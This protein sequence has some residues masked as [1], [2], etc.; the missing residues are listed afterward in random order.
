MNYFKIAM[1][2]SFSFSAFNTTLNAS[3][4]SFEN[5]TLFDFEGL[6]PTF[7][8]FLKLKQ[9][10]NQHFDLR[11][12]QEGGYGGGQEG[13]HGGGED[14][15]KAYCDKIYFED[16]VLSELQNPNLEKLNTIVKNEN[17]K[18]QGELLSILYEYIQS[19]QF[20]KSSPLFSQV[21]FLKENKDLPM[22]D[23][24]YHTIYLLGLLNVIA[25]Q[26]TDLLNSMYSIS[27]GREESPPKEESFDERVLSLLEFIGNKVVNPVPYNLYFS[28]CL[29]RVCGLDV[30]R[31]EIEKYLWEEKNEKLSLEIRKSF[32]QPLSYIQKLVF[33]QFPSI[34]QDL[35]N[36]EEKIL[37]VETLFQSIEG[38]MRAAKK[39][40]DPETLWEKFD[41]I[42]A[43]LSSYD[44]EGVQKI[45]IARKIELIE[46][47]RIESL[48]QKASISFFKESDDEKAEKFYNLIFEKIQEKEFNTNDKVTASS[49]YVSLFFY[50]K[51]EMEKAYKWADYI[52]KK[53]DLKRK[54]L[55]LG[56]LLP[57]TSLYNLYTWMGDKNNLEKIKP[58]YEKV[59][60][61][62]IKGFQ[63]LIDT[64]K[65][66]IQSFRQAQQFK[67]MKEKNNVILS[68][69]AIRAFYENDYAGALNLYTKLYN[70]LFL[71]PFE[72]MDTQHQRACWREN[73]IPFFFYA[74]G[75][76]E[77]V[78]MYTSTFLRLLREKKGDFSHEEI[79]TVMSLMV[80]YD[81]MGESEG[82]SSLTPFYEKANHQNPNFAEVSTTLAQTSR[83]EFVLAKAY[84]ETIKR[85]EDL[86]QA[87]ENMK[88]EKKRQQEQENAQKQERER[89]EAAQEAAQEE[90]R[91][92]LEK[93]KIRLKQEKKRKV[94]QER[95]RAQKEEQEKR[96][97]EE[98]KRQ[99][100]QR[101][102][103][104]AL[105]E[106]KE[107]KRQAEEEKSKRELLEKEEI[108]KQKAL[109]KSA[110]KAA[111]KALKKKASEVVSEVVSTETSHERCE[112]I[113]SLE[114]SLET[115]DEET[116]DEETSHH[117]HN[118]NTGEGR[119][120]TSLSD[121]SHSVEDIELEDETYPLPPQPLPMDPQPI[122][123][124][125][126][127]TMVPVVPYVITP[128]MPPVVLQMMLP[129]TAPLNIMEPPVLSFEGVQGV[130]RDGVFYQVYI[131][132]AMPGILVYTPYGTYFQPVYLTNPL[133]FL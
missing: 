36:Y 12:F 129:M 69:N 105:N 128:I 19:Q 54:K 56:E 115:R 23:D 102:Q 26:N 41:V 15:V 37:K 27:K 33:P 49:G 70:E 38:K 58:F 57:I 126:A 104:E 94:A 79:Q 84:F 66:R 73:H 87:Q 80:L 132:Q 103:N 17:I 8:N 53:I 45:K 101:L 42:I 78:D 3:S 133:V 35:R 7:S 83:K 108:K 50:A 75:D 60:S 63:T 48:I 20:G 11:Q 40:D 97:E 6:Q 14:V 99:E 96:E 127:Q 90:A 113:D 130:I 22:E 121:F 30:T 72:E 125:I 46:N 59:L 86:A 82:K 29:Q 124:P 119:G 18:S 85:N 98:A 112:K 31:F 111:K 81:W 109:G 68:L 28:L 74:A 61:P 25:S 24:C 39:I 2:C 62:D 32:E 9:H 95:K 16:K 43:L 118:N 110:Q 1:L 89:Q 4:H 91:T 76:M 131:Q 116:R 107:R 21:I 52:L 67:K 122:Y 34:F 106:A 100:E 51:D 120:D 10:F 13:G 114:T 88:K 44:L 77:K 117:H 93:E 47:E 5:I 71:L 65:P 123:P 64:L 55:L 92:A